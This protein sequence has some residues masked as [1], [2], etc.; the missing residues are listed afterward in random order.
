[1]RYLLLL[2]VALA[3]CLAFYAWQW[4][5]LQPSRA[6]IQSPEAGSPEWYRQAYGEVVRNIDRGDLRQARERLRELQADR[7]V[8][9]DRLP[10][11]PLAA[12]PSDLHSNPMHASGVDKVS[13]SAR[14]P[15]YRPADAPLGPCQLRVEFR[16]S[17][18]NGGWQL[19]TEVIEPENFSPLSEEEA[20]QIRQQAQ[21]RIR[22][23]TRPGWTQWSQFIFTRVDCIRATDPMKG[24][25]Q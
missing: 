20:G 12:V 25:S 13:V 18:Q 1:M 14:V 19:R 5:Q 21:D 9:V 17:E 2:C 11:E 15:D 10:A 22:P 6:G 3:G 4:W 7:G 24:V 8:P 16:A 23:D